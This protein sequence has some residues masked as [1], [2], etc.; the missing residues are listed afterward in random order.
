MSLFR[1]NM[2]G[3]GPAGARGF[4]RSTFG[5]VL[6]SRLYRRVRMGAADTDTDRSARL[7]RAWFSESEQ[8]I[9][10]ASPKLASH[11]VFP[12]TP[13]EFTHI[14]NHA[15]VSNVAFF[16][17]AGHTCFR[18]RRKG[19]RK[20]KAVRGCIVDGF[21]S[22]MHLVIIKKGEKDIPGLTGTRAALTQ[23]AYQCP[24]RACPA[25]VCKGWCVCVCA[26]A[27]ARA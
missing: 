24:P 21:L 5:R 26:R 14:A 6:A 18:E 1:Q 19:E 8:H 7:G 9:F 4:S 23:R 2:P 17:A 3:G 16:R 27:R 10:V 25:G 20:R 12:A 11:G 15:A 22:V 13:V